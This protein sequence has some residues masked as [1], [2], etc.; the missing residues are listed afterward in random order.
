MYCAPYAFN[1]VAQLILTTELADYY[2]ALP[3][4]SRT[5]LQA[6]F[7]SKLDILRNAVTLVETAYT[8]RHAE[9]LREC[10]VYLAGD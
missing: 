10:V 6:L 9:L 8:L 3:I 1:D 5:L 2:C 7:S 4:L